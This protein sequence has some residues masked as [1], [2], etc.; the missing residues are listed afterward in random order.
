MSEIEKVEAY[1][2]PDGALHATLHEA[3]MGMWRART[4]R[5]WNVMSD[6]LGRDPD[7]D[8]VRRVVL[9]HLDALMGSMAEA[10]RLGVKP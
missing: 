6:E 3:E 7:S 4:Q 5:L 8:D 9:K 2:T 10:K 1:R